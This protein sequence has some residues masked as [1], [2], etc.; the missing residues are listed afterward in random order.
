MNEQLIVKKIW[1]P[2]LN[3]Y[4]F[5][6]VRVPIIR[7]EIKED[8]PVIV[9]ENDLLTIQ[10]KEQEWEDRSPVLT[11]RDD[12]KIVEEEE[13]EE[14]ESIFRDYFRLL[15]EQQDCVDIYVALNQDSGSED[16]ETVKNFFKRHQLPDICS[17]RY[18]MRQIYDM[19]YC[20][21]EDVII[22]T[23]ELIEGELDTERIYRGLDM[24]RED[25]KE[26]A[27]TFVK[28]QFEC[29]DEQEV[30]VEQLYS[31]YIPPSIVVLNL[32]S[33]LNCETRDG[34]Y[35]N[36][37]LVQVEETPEVVHEL[38]RVSVKGLDT[39]CLS[40]PS[41]LSCRIK[42][43]AG[44]RFFDVRQEAVRYYYVEGLD[45]LRL[46]YD[47][48]L[49]RKAVKLKRYSEDYMLDILVCD[50][51]RYVEIDLRYESRRTYEQLIDLI[52]PPSIEEHIEIDATEIKESNWTWCRRKD[53]KCDC[54]I[55]SLM[56]S[57]KAC[58]N[59]KRNKLS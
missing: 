2:P 54:R 18:L 31:P 45:I 25:E 34:G 32:D 27:Q 58:H 15:M 17:N 44:G 52:G 1:Y 10:F 14:E 42:F 13:E 38:Y 28:L 26:L 3:M 40:I 7:P 33:K 16:D 46:K 24:R 20:S 11:Y 4:I 19:T 47:R 49:G 36:A 5:S 53:K 12:L 59:R 50:G 6:E 48:R 57:E 51:T 22:C 56:M 39:I 8:Y 55:R 37:T 29:L 43:K 23:D 30:V 21:E 41:T 9:C 35:Q